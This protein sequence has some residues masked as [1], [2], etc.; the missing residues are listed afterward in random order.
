MGDAP[1]LTR[2]GLSPVSA[3]LARQQMFINQPHLLLDDHPLTWIGYGS[4]SW[5]DQPNT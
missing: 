2:L 4:L 5:A 3:L 1:F